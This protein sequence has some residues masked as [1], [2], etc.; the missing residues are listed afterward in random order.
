M[1]ICEFCG[2]DKKVLYSSSYGGKLCSKHYMQHY[3]TGKLKER[4][5]KDVNEIIF[6][7]DFAEIILYDKGHVEK[8]RYI[9]DLNDVSKCKNIKWSEHIEG[10]VW[11]KIRGKII[12]IHNYLLNNTSKKIVVDHIDG[13]K[14]NNRRIN[15]RKATYSQNNMNAKKRKTNTS[16]KAGISFNQNRGKFETYI[17]VNKKRI[18]LGYFDEFINATQARKDAEIKYFGEYRYE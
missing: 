4:F 8:S 9:I 15:L 3:H 14:K 13:N 1:K 5:M 2:S 11:G 10:Y 18:F 12:F 17:N 6:Y 16:G 7:H